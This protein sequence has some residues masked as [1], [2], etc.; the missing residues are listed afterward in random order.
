MFS[1]DI[2][3][4]IK[5]TKDTKNVYFCLTNYSYGEGDK[6]QGTFIELEK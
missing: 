1:F 5:A 2:E 4:N 6:L 3:I